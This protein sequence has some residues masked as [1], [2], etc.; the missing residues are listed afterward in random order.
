MRHLCVPTT[1]WPSKDGR[2]YIAKIQ[3]TARKLEFLLLS[4]Q[5]LVEFLSALIGKTFPNFGQVW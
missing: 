4:W 1:S 3:G 2:A 5:I